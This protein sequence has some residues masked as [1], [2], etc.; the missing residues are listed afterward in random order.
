MLLQV[1]LDSNARRFPSS[2]VIGGL[3]RVRRRRRRRPFDL[4]RRVSGLEDVSQPRE[5]RPTHH[6]D[7]EDANSLMGKKLGH[8]RLQNF[9]YV[10][11]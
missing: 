7:V 10:R 11:D 5:D 4:G 2:H 3:R 9:P 6:E 8:F 1:V